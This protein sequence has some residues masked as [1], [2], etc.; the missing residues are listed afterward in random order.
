MARITTGEQLA[1]RCEELATNYKTVYMW[2]T[3]GQPVT[4]SIIAQ[5]AEQYKKT[6]HYTDAKLAALRLLIG[7]GYFAF[8]CVGTIKGLLWDWSADKAK[9]NGGATYRSNGVE[10]LGADYMIAKCR[11]IST[12]FNEIAVGE[13]VWCPGHIGV[14]I[15]NGLSVECT[16]GWNANKVIITAC[17]CNKAGYNRRNW[18]KHG[19]LPFISYPSKTA[20]EAGAAAT[21]TTLAVGDV[22]NFTGSKHYTS[23]AATTGKACKPG[24]AKITAIAKGKKA[25]PYHLVA[26]TGEGSTVYGWVNAADIK[27][28]RYQVKVT[29]TLNIRKGPGTNYGI[30][31]VIR[32]KG[33]YTI[34]NESTGT[35]ATKWGKLQNGAGWISLDYTRKL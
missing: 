26:V 28:I 19:K 6:N 20:A 15:G 34:V 13:A 32:D 9:I 24:K 3:F 30:A 23:A 16:T 11:E 1:A 25:H 31:G 29:A 18:T 33:T 10:D 4:E 35:G 5:K 7:K 17:N 14:Y 2:G 27:A 8:D 12:D 22:V 21:A